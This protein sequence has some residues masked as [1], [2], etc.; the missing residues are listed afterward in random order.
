MIGFGPYRIMW[1]AAASAALLAAGCATTAPTIQ[2]GPA[3]QAAGGM[4]SV[5]AS[6]NP[7]SNNARNIGMTVGGVMGVVAARLMGKKGGELLVGGMAGTLMGGLVGH[8]VDERR[9]NLYRIATRYDLKMASAT[10]SAQKLGAQPLPGGTAGD[11]VGLDVELATKRDE[12]IPGTAQLTPG[13]RVYLGQIARQYSS[14][15][16]TAATG[17]Q[18]TGPQR[19]EATERQL[20]IVGHTDERDDRSGTGLAQLSA[21]RAR[22]VAQ[23]F[24][25]NG[26]PAQNIHYQGAGDSL[27]IASN[28]TAQGRRDNNRLEIVDTPNLALLRQFARQRAPDPANFSEAAR[29]PAAPVLVP[30]TG[31]GAARTSGER[32]AAGLSGYGF[33]GKPLQ[34]DYRVN[35]GQAA[36][37]SMFSIIRTA[38]AA[39]PVIIGSCLHDRPHASTPIRDLATG[40]ALKIDDALAGLYGQ[41]WYGTQGRA[42]V[43]LLHV[44]VPQDGGAPVPPV[45]VE[46]FRR[47]DGGPIRE[48]R[49]PNARV[50]VYRGSAATLYRV[51]LPGDR[52]CIDL[53][54][55]VRSATA[56][57]AILYPSGGRE[58]EA[59][60]AFSS[61]G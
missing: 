26:I 25:A 52:Q 23:V 20:L 21:Q 2:S 28:A 41:P 8:L 54:V 58:L 1:M 31:P 10:L 56:E 35:L 38:Y 15:A 18:V 36:S 13:A 45:T 4:R 33:A 47:Q 3:P 50:N 55:P 17:G 53:D 61:E 11:A 29:Q 7:C 37:H 43:A 16:P 27:P 32:T 34:S 42:A 44:Y 30:G 51:F 48:A 22:A 14:G 5:F 46:I 57:G 49:F 60:G 12:F 59:V 24:A 40:A 39:E 6:P 19:A 9:C